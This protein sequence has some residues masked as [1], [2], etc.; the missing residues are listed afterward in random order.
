M[1]LFDYSK[2]LFLTILLTAGCQSP[3][4][5]AYLNPPREFKWSYARPEE[6]GMSTERINVL[7]EN[8]LK[9]DTKKASH[10]KE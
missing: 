9:K 1:K 8:L 6:V 3:V 7:K 5:N 4:Q 2:L 10:C